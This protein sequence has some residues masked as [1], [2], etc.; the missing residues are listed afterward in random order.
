MSNLLRV[1]Q[2]LQT[3]DRFGQ[4]KK[5]VI[6][7]IADVDPIDKTRVFCGKNPFIKKGAKIV[8]SAGTTGAHISYRIANSERDARIFQR[9]LA[10]GLHDLN[11]DLR[12]TFVFNCYPLGIQLPSQVF[13]VDAATRIDIVHHLSKIVANQCTNVM[14]LAQP[15][16]AKTMIDSDV[17]TSLR[18]KNIGFL[19][20]GSWYPQSF[21]R[22]IEAMITDSGSRPL[23]VLSVFGTA[24]TGVGV[25]FVGKTENQLRDQNQS[26]VS[27]MIIR[28]NTDEY[29]VESLDGQLAVT[30]LDPSFEPTLV[31][32][33]TGDHVSHITD[34]TFFMPGWS[35][36]QVVETI[37]ALLFKNLT[38]ASQL[39][40]AF[41]IRDHTVHFQSRKNHTASASMTQIAQSDLGTYLSHIGHTPKTYDWNTYPFKQP[42]EKKP[43]F[44]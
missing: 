40:G 32:Y 5:P 28:I 27:D 39:T 9:L 29:F 4:K 11:I 38:L 3:H 1:L 24:E 12:E 25:G 6:E 31:R 10:L 43:V 44:F 36:N 2:Q 37:L 8:P 16:F 19:L 22:F 14:F 26:L 34:Q 21:S 7:T 23:P 35:N 30:V 17:L 42:P 15:H 18:G 41:L 13:G 33:L 20:G